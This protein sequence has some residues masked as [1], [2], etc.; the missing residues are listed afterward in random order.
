MLL[1]IGM[2]DIC[3][4]GTLNVLEAARHAHTKVIFTSTAAVYGETPENPIKETTPVNPSSFYGASKSAAETYCRLYNKTYD[5]PVVIV[6]L[7]NVYGPR[8]RKY[9]MHDILMKLNRNPHTLNMLGSGNQKRDFIYVKDAID[10]L[11]LVSVNNDCYGETFNLGTGLST[12]IKKVVTCITKIL[13]ANPVVKY[14]GS[15]WKGDIEILVADISELGRIGFTPK[16]SLE[17]G[18]TKFISWYQ[19]AEK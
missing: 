9:L 1:V 2:L 8:Q 7:F 11:V 19:K 4:K 16:C 10:G 13:G 6:R 12:S 18:I 14:T 17:Q 15:S 3:L 5:L